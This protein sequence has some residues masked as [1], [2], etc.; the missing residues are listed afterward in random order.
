MKMLP[1]PLVDWSESPNNKDDW[2]LDKREDSPVETCT[3]S[4]F[5]AAVDGVD[6][7]QQ[8]QDQ[9]LQ[10]QQPQPLLCPHGYTCHIIDLGDPKKGIPNRGHCIKERH[11]HKT[12]AHGPVWHFRIR[13]GATSNLGCSLDSQFHANGAFFQYDRHPCICE[14]G[15]ITC[16]VARYK[17]NSE[18]TENN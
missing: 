3:T 18:E 5:D 17:E 2:L 4:M 15:M 16:T 9:Q 12:H 11:T 13:T 8:L 14:Q 10:E 7:D 1:P 6:N